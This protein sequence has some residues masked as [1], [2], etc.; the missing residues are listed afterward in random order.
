MTYLA[1][2]IETV[3]NERAKDYYLQKT[4]A[5]PSNYKDA[6]KIEQAIN[7]ARQ[8][9][10]D[11]AAL[12]W[13]TG[14]IVCISAIDIKEGK[15]HTFSGPNEREVLTE[16]FKLLNTYSYT[17]PNGV[18]YADTNSVT[19]IGKSSDSF[20]KP[21][22]VGRALY[23]NIGLPQA[24]RSRRPISD[25]DHMFSFSSACQ[26]RGKLSD[27]AFGLNI[28]GKLSDGG[29]VQDMYD[30]DEWDAINKYCLQDSAIV[31][32]MVRRYTKEFNG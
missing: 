21:F 29:K 26:Q 14:Q 10:I 8:K 24:L 9:D 30:A 31:A 20:D 1:W 13:W 11:K 28:D 16:F 6:E 15:E 22:T 23:Q 5:A 4:Y 18:Q 12:S 2:D 25:V 7:K 17:D 27:Y 32:E 3:K 19:L